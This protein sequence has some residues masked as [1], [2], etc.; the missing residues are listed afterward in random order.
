MLTLLVH[1]PHFE[2][3]CY[4]H[5]VQ[6]WYRNIQYNFVYMVLCKYYTVY[7]L[8]LKINVSWKQHHGKNMGLPRSFKLLQSILYFLLFHQVLTIVCQDFL[9][10]TTICV[11]TCLFNV[12]FLMFFLLTETQ[13]LARGC[14]SSLSIVTHFNYCISSFR[15][16]FPQ[17]LLTC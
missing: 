12:W 14:I 7:N 16:I 3:H 1:R 17:R 15:E 4:W 2:R 5:M 13:A 8:L 10:C 6:K 9:S 11:D